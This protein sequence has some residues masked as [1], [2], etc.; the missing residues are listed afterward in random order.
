MAL[1]ANTISTGLAP[2]R[3]GGPTAAHRLPAVYP[4]WRLMVPAQPDHALNS[5]GARSQ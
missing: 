2:S 4:P 1:T 5:V 3:P